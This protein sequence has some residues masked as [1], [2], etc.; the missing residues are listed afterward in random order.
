M[1]KT[2]CILSVIFVV[3]FSSFS[4]NNI[5]DYK[6]I[7][8]P[9][10]FEFLKE[11]DQ[12]QVNSLAKFLFN[13]YGYSAYMQDEDLPQDLNNN[14][15][16]GLL[17]D[18]VKDGGVFK[19]KLRI[20]LKD[21][22]GKVV[23]SSRVGETREKE[24]A[25]AYNLA[26]RDAFETFQNMNYE[27]EPNEAIISKSAVKVVAVEDKKQQQEIDKLKEEIKS[28]KEERQDAP[29]TENVKIVQPKEVVLTP[30]V[31]ESLT[32]ADVLYAQPKEN[33]YQLV[34]S[35]PKVVMVLVKT[36]VKD[37]FSVKDSDAIVYKKDD[38]WMY[39]ED[40]S[41]L[42]GKAINIKF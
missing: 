19:T 11:K 16:L 41:I 2:L 10:Q 4:Q 7:V 25:K 32:S 6:Y 15:C 13:K 20:D 33:G 23:M 26:L 8:I 42:K 28:L 22:N 3:S 24:Y 5:N 38:V 39:S 30:K 1:T 29:M 17:A 36:G 40:G 21:C 9:S 12:Y 27:Y 35:T 31:E 14:R 18:V 34:D 37:V